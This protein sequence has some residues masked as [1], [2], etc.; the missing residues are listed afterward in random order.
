MPESI[1]EEKSEILKSYCK[2]HLEKMLPGVIKSLGYANET[3]LFEKIIKRT[4]TM[5][6]SIQRERKK[7]YIFIQ[8]SIP[9][10]INIYEIQ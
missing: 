2:L 9:F 5:N 6:Q 3:I 8:F 7:P 1:K 4:S 10:G